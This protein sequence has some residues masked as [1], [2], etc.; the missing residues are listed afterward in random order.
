MARN[1]RISFLA[2]QTKGY[3]TVLD[4]GT[5][6]GLVLLK[7]FKKRYIKEAIASDLREKPLG[8]AKQNLKGYPVTYIL[9][10]GFKSVKKPFDLAIIAGMGAYLISDILKNAPFGK[11]TYLIQANDN[12]EVLRQFLC[13]NEFKI[14]DEYLIED[15]FD[16]IVL[17][18]CRGKMNLLE[19]D[20]YLGPVLKHRL[21]AI[22]YYQKK[23]QQIKKIMTKADSERY[24]ILEKVYN[25]YKNS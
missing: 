3:Q 2:E 23:A 8:Q 20:L 15:K 6:H 19:Q 11:Q 10:D 9:S 24:E 18:I 1:K 7:A 21:E 13:D 4:I 12:L 5:D 14:I 25:I 22:K 16:Y 17:K